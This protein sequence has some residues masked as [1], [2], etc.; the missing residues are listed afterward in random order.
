M[1]GT[2]SVAVIGSLFASLSNAAAFSAQAT[3]SLPGDAVSAAEDSIGAAL[4][5]AGRIA[6]DGAPETA[7]GLRDVAVAGFFDGLQAGCLVAAGVC[8][9]GAM[10]ALRWLPAQPTTDQPD[11]SSESGRLISP[12]VPRPRSEGAS[13][14]RAHP[15]EG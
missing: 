4:A 10:A 3:R 14:A 5:T 8:A 7:A 6:A 15:R 11:R 9:F 12:G 1:G 13:L 2:L